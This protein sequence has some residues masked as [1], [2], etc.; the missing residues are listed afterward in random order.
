LVNAFGNI[1]VSIPSYGLRKPAD[2]PFAVRGIEQS[3]G[4]LAF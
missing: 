1:S 3:F 4:V 2:S